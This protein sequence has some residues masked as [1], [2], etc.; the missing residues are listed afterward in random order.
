MEIK[1]YRHTVKHTEHI[2]P[3]LG[4]KPIISYYQTKWS[5]CPSFIPGKDSEIVKLEEKVVE[6]AES[7]IRRK[8]Q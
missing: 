2:P 5:D 4:D 6:V 8:K 3:H 1:M 7:C